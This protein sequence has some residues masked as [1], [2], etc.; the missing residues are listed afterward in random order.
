M[1]LGF[2]ALSQ[3]HVV[4]AHEFLKP[5]VSWFYL[6]VLLAVPE[7]GQ[8]ETDGKDNWRVLYCLRLFIPIADAQATPW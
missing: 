7:T 1:L 5:A 8:A 3:E 2:S 6:I 4:G